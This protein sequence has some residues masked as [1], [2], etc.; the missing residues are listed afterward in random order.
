MKRVG[1]KRVHLY[2]SI[3][4]KFLK[5]QFNLSWWAVGDWGLKGRLIAKGYKGTF[6]DDG[7]VSRI[8]VAMVVT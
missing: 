6:G 3:Y 1:H 8:S 2:D 5:M 4:T 7:N